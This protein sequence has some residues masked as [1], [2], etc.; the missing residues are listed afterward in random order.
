MHANAPSH[1]C[2]HDRGSYPRY[3]NYYI[4]LTVSAAG[5]C[6]DCSARPANKRR[7]HLPS[8][9]LNSPLHQKRRKHPRVPLIIP[10][11]IS[12]PFYSGGELMRRNSSAVPLK[13]KQLLRL[14]SQQKEHR[15][16]PCLNVCLFARVCFQGEA[17]MKMNGNQR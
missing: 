8:H 12:V 14:R 9:P 2:L 17:F 3:F 4:S 15:K 6:H 10:V 5:A 13:T 7:L 1:T 16:Q 11:I